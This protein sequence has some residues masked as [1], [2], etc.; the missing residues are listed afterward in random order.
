M[1]VYQHEWDLSWAGPSCL[2]RVVLLVGGIACFHYFCLLCFI[3]F[4]SLS[5]FLMTLNFGF[6]LLQV[7]CYEHFPPLALAWRGEEV[8]PFPC[9]ARWKVSNTHHKVRK[10]ISTFQQDLEL[11]AAAQVSTQYFLLYLICLFWKS[12]SNSYYAWCRLSD[13][14]GPDGSWREMLPLIIHRLG[15]VSLKD[16]VDC[17]RWDHHVPQGEVLALG[18]GRSGG[19]C[20]PTFT[21]LGHRYWGRGK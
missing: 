6:S 17:Y 10:P 7:W 11:L 5:Y 9:M 19:L 13:I 2:F 21:P 4:L 3:C 15:L 18:W 20:G 14:H 1:D 12:L 8:F 16:C